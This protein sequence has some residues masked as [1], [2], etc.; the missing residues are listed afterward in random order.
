VR[1]LISLITLF[2]FSLHAATITDDKLT[3]GKKASAS[4]KEIVFDTNDGTANKKLSV[5][6][7]TKKLSIT[8]DEA[9]V[10]DGTASDKALTFNR[11]GS[12]AQV[13]WN[14]A[15]D[16]LQFSNDGTTYKDLGTGSGGGG[17][18]GVNVLT[19]DSF[20]DAVGGVLTDWTNT[21]GTLTQQT[22]TNSVEGDAKYF[23]FVAST[24]GQYFE[25]VKVVPTNFNGSGCQVD[26]KKLNIA[27]D[28]LFKVEALDASNNVLATENVKV[29][30]WNKLPTLS[31]VCPA[32]GTN[33][34]I[35]V[36]SLAAGTLQ[37][38]KAYLGS[39]QNIGS[40][41]VSKDTNW[42][43]YNPVTQ[44]LG[45]TSSTGFQW[46][47]K[48]DSLILRGPIATGIGTA[49]EARIYF[50]GSLVSSSSIATIELAGGTVGTN[51]A[52]ASVGSVFLMEPNVNYITIGRTNGVYWS[53]KANGDTITAGS[54]IYVYATIPIQGWS[55]VIGQDTAISNDQ[56]AWHISAN[57]GGGVAFTTGVS[58]YTAFENSSLDMVLKPGSASAK[59]PC[60]GTN[61][62]TGLTC[63][64][65]LEQFGAVFTNPLIG[66]HRVCVYAGGTKGNANQ[67]TIQLVETAPNSQTIIQ[68]SGTRP[69]IADGSSGVQ[70]ASYNHCGFFTFSDVKERAIRLMYES[71]NTVLNLVADRNATYGQRDF[72]IT[73]ENISFGQ[74]RPILT[75][76]TNVTPGI[77][78]SKI[79]DFSFAFGGSAL[80]N[81]CT[82]GTCFLSQIGNAV[83]SVVNVSTSV[84]TLNFSKTY[85]KIQCGTDYAVTSDGDVGFLVSYLVGNKPFVCT[86]CN[87]FALRGINTTQTVTKDV[88]AGLKCKGEL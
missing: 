64:A 67:T 44:G 61:P 3:V 56:A 15:T 83:S 30:T 66:L 19:N 36:T 63:S 87:S 8:S 55:E 46:K 32:A 60:S 52:T 85:S 86:N 40:V 57:I 12:N 51:T 18:S 10:G 4:A 31:F 59:I 81:V 47:R 70:T 45:S 74:D 38:D 11:G 84:Y 58:S 80:D 1:K 14:E 42:A 27:T 23:Q 49:V 72:T 50:P 17:S 76:G 39:N 34:K 28:D 78:S 54:N 41:A 73:V 62:A 7:I 26:F 53:D 71:D 79:E 22:Y 37:G 65:G 21:G 24:S 48:G 16:K 82:T 6:K 77:T 9:I 29:S 69:M 5:D 43:T 13:K 20:E 88:F 68:E 33:F 75:G 35:R 2:S 25:M